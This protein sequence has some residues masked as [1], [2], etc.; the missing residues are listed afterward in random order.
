MKK[1]LLLLLSVSLI[2]VS[3]VACGGPD[4][5]NGINPLAGDLQGIIP[6]PDDVDKDE[7][8]D[9]ESIAG[10]G[11]EITFDGRD[12][13]LPGEG[14]DSMIDTERPFY[15]A[16]TGVVVSNDNTYVTIEDTEGN[17]TVFIICDDTIFPFSSDIVVGETI[18][19][20][21]L[22]N[23]P[24]PMIYPPQYTAVVLVA[25]APDYASVRVNLFHTWEDYAEGY[26]VSVDRS[27]AFQIN[28]STEV[29]LEDGFE[30]IGNDFNN[31]R[32]IVIYGISTHSIPEI[33]LAHKVI[34]FYEEIAPAF[35]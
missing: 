32:A 13:T 20:W 16:K 30:F 33:A 27:F 12:I 29:I 24:V 4:L 7:D 26:F 9:M 10:D 5:D 19:G 25:D 15:T 2:A 21:F 18:T 14:G 6:L 28:D 23:A 35:G 1:I 11:S 22:T 17:K 31:R 34:V 3:A 8:R